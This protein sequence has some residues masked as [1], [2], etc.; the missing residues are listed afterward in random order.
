[1]TAPSSSHRCESCGDTFTVTPAALAEKAD[2]WTGCLAW[3][4]QSYAPTRDPELLG[5][6]TME[7][8]S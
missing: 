1:M 7:A 2:Q 3:Q 5:G 8:S 6:I 4:C